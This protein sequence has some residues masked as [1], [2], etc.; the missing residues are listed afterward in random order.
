MT[1]LWLI[2]RLLHHYMDA[3]GRRP[4][5]TAEERESRLTSPLLPAAAGHTTRMLRHVAIARLARPVPSSPFEATVTKRKS[6][7]ALVAKLRV[8]A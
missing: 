3:T 4:L 5:E 1:G 8:N 7:G 6:F 2:S